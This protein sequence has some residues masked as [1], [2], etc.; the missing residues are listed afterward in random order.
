MPAKAPLLL[1][2]A[3]AGPGIGSGHVARL[4]SLA[5]AWI[6]VG[7]RAKLLTV[8][9]SLTLKI[10][11]ESLGV[12]VIAL[13]AAHP[14]SSDLA[15]SMQEVLKAPK[16][17]WLVVDGYGFD[18][19]YLA[20]LRA[21]GARVLRVDDGPRGE[22]PCDVF[23]DPNP[24]AETT[25]PS[26]LAE[27]LPLLGSRWAPLRSSFASAGEGRSAHGGVH[28]LLI[29][30]GGEDPED[31]TRL[32]LR[33]L[34]RVKCPF[35][36]VV[37]VGPDNSLADA[38]S[39]LAAGLPVR[40]EHA[41]DMPALMGK[42]DLA[43]IGGGV[44]MLEA[45][46][47]GLPALV[48]TVAENQESGAA[49]LAKRGLV[50]ALGRARDIDEERIALALDALMGDASELNRLS[51]SGRGVVDG[52]GSSRVAEIL[53]ALSEPRLSENVVRFRAATIDDALEIWRIANDPAVRSNSF[54][55]SPIPW[56]AHARW[57][58]SRLSDRSGSFL[59]ADLGCIAGHFRLTSVAPGV[60]EVH[61]SVQASFRGKG[62]GTLL[63]KK[64]RETAFSQID[65]AEIVGAVLPGNEPSIRSFLSSGFAQE[66]EARRDAAS[67]LLFRCRRHSVVTTSRA[68]GGLG[69]D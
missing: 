16:G 68:P 1:L 55:P 26:L 57:F 24:G 62:L 21:G 54:D 65:I 56:D 2:R 37:V 44:T 50:R 9:P 12:E 52:R 64:A 46:A 59:V 41:A 63:L 15:Q 51:N 27:A 19:I 42:A 35:E 66:G 4:L 39:E 36:A 60:C 40:L 20:S 34:R 25:A 33:A 18:A 5:E 3:D 47:A 31:A 58:A 14:D 49:A 61:F 22:V 69:S 23:L 67:G 53:L 17:I 28:N 10:R 32:A 45:C 43:L 29:S 38:L 11:A 30:F 8:A 7:G 13:P 6:D 48:A